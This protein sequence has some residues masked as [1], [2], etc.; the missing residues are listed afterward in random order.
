MTADIA[1]RVPEELMA[2]VPAEVRGSGRDDVRLMV[3]RGTEVSI[4]RS[5]SWPG[6]CGPGTSWS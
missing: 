1:I 5:G 3:S 4:T 2:S 6:S